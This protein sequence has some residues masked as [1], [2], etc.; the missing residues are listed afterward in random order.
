MNSRNLPQA[1]DESER[2]LFVKI[3][4]K[5]RRLPTQL[6]AARNKVKELEQ[7]A[8]QIGMHHLVQNQESAR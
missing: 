6:R 7:V 8:A 1:D 2:L 5:Q 3:K 4:N